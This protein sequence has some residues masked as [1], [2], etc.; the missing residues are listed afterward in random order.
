MAEVK[1]LV[2]KQVR[3]I[4]S[5]AAGKFLPAELG[6]GANGCM[7]SCLFGDLLGR[8]FERWWTGDQAGA[9]DLHTRLLPLLNLAGHY[10]ARYMLKRRGVLTSLAERAP[11]AQV[12]DDLD[13]REISILLRAVEKDIEVFPF[14][15]E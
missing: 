9:R 12:L 10:F 1:H 14:G 13:K 11:S 5:G 6:R 8:V 15:P 2:G 4:F 7:A 3:T